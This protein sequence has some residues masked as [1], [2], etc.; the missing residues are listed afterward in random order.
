MSSSQSVYIGVYF[1]VYMPKEKYISGERQCPK[2]KKYVSSEFCPNDGTKT[3]EIEGERLSDFYDLCQSVFGDGDQFQTGNIDNNE[4][5][6]VMANSDNQ[7]GHFYVSDEIEQ[8]LP[9][10]DY[11]GDWQI[12]ANALDER[13]I[14]YEKHFG[15]VSYWS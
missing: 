10:E 11:S 1:K 8:P 15:V 13:G 2:C 7:P 14:K 5:A 4:F 9:Q 6:I 12:L 3:I